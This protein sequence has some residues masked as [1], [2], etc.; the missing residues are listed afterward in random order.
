[1]NYPF[2]LWLFSLAPIIFVLYLLKVTR[3]RR[4]VSTLVFWQRIVE[5]HRRHALFHRLRN[6]LSLLLNLLIL[7][8]LILAAARLRW[9]GFSSVEGNTFLIIDNRARMEARDAAGRTR[10]D[11]AK[12]LAKSL[13]GK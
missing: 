5:E 9:P 12:R 10:L 7:L 4:T 8:C 2:A 11:V 1:M 13:N 6:L 3:R